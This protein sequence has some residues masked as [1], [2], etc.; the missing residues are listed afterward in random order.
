MADCIYIFER[1]ESKYLLDARAYST[2]MRGMREHITPE[3]YGRYTIY[4]LYF[5][6]PNFRLVRQSLDKPIY[7]EKLRLRSYTLPKADSEVFVEL[8]KKYDGVVYKRRV[9]MSYKQA[10]EYLM[11]GKNPDPDA[12]ILREIDWFKSFYPMRPAVNLSYAREAF[13]GKEDDALRITFDSDILWRSTNVDL[14]KGAFG[15]QLLEP[16][17]RLMELK[18]PGA[19]PLWLCRLLD[20]AQIYPTSFSKYGSSYLRMLQSEEKIK[21][22]FTCA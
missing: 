3:Q 1:Y 17:M 12:Q 9:Q 14:S 8:K 5:D 20:A 21:D 13:A 16:G 2:L 18:T 7:K 6:T 19:I 4:N 22:V 11:L 10:Y 15:E